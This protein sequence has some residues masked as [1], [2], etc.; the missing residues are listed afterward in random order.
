MQS[1]ITS[2]QFTFVAGLALA[3]WLILTSVSSAQADTGSVPPSVQLVI[4]GHDFPSDA[5]ALLVQEIGSEMPVLA[6]NAEL[7]LNPA[8]TMKV[9]TTLAA[10]EKL[11]PAYTWRTQIYALGDVQGGVLTGDLLIRGGGDPF[12]VEENVRSMLK[13]LQRRGIQRISGNLI[14]DTA[15]FD[16]LVS[17]GDSL[18][19][20]SNRAYNVLPHG[21]MMNFQTVSFYF[22]PHD[23]GRDV[24]I[25][26]DPM[27]PNLTID[28]RLRLTNAPCTGFQRGIS[29]SEDRD[30][31]TV[32]FSGQFPGACEEYAITRAVLDAPQYAYGL[33]RQLWQELGGSLDGN[34]QSGSLPADT[35]ISPLVVWQSPPLSDVIKSINKYSNNMMTRQLLLTLGLEYAGIPAN[36]ENGIAAVHS[37]LADIGVDHSALV[38]ANGAGLAREA[39]LTASMLNAVLQRAYVIPNMPEFMAALP[40]AGLDG[41][42]RDRLADEPGS[43]RVHVKTGSLSGVAAIA[44]YVHAYSGKRYVVVALVNHPRSDTGTGQELGDSLLRWALEQ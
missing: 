27:L 5:Y 13:T 15:V 33:F 30:Y 43:G 6:V 38:M 42:M 40:L 4:N 41:T 20:Q 31:N 37:Y 7:A 25:K 16:P 2:K 21:L 9:L 26:A 36:A 39:R 12:L 8:S 29:F 28:N 11:G 3:T 23:N 1:A 17:Q 14:L 32:I 22:Y 44:G 34:L 24:I 19:N 35:D 18:D 10:L